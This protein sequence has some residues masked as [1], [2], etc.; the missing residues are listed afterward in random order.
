[1]KR[2]PFILAAAAAVSGIGLAMSAQA[3]ADRGAS[4]TYTALVMGVTA[5][6]HMLPAISRT[7]PA[8]LMWL[9]CLVV[10]VY[11]HAA[12][13][14]GV[15]RR[16]GDQRATAVRS[17]EHTRA[18]REQLNAIAARPAATV[19]DALAQATARSAQATAA[20]T[21]CEATTPSRCSTARASTT[22]AAARTQAL[23]TELAE[24][25]RADELRAQLATAASQHD[26]SRAAATTDPGAAALAAITHLPAELIQ[27]AAALLMAVLAELLAALLWTTA[28]PPPPRRTDHDRPDATYTHSTAIPVH[29]AMDTPACVLPAVPRRSDPRDRDADH[30]RGIPPHQHRPR[31]PDGLHQ[32]G[33]PVHDVAGNPGSP[34]PQPLHADRDA[35]ESRTTATRRPSHRLGKKRLSTVDTG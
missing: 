15:D 28:L 3:A 5:A 7:I 19:A 23:A 24:A 20:L 16:A 9:A 26:A 18:L 25:H 6:A 33:P 4:L 30:G 2:R 21:R 1:M 11:G 35:R 32:P 17:T 12:F 31:A 8:R 27:T 14:A 22:T 13:I 34:R 10:V 29:Q